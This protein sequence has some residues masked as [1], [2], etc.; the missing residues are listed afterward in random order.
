VIERFDVFVI[1]GGGTGS[2]VAFQLGR[3]SRL[4]IA[5]AERERLG[6]ECSHHGCVPTKVML[7]SGKIA[8]LG[9]DAGRFGVRIPAVEVDLRAV[10]RRAREVIE[11]QS[12]EGAAPF[13]RLGVRVFLQEARLA[14]HRR[15]ELADGTTV[16]ADR[17]VLATGTAPSIPPV[18]GLGD[19][20]HWTNREAIWSPE[21]PP[22][23]LAVIGAG[24]IGVEFAQIYAAFGTRVTM[25]EALPRILPA[26]DADAAAAVAPALEEAGIALR[27]DTSIASAIHSGSG[28]RLDLGGEALHADE[29]L[30]AAG[31]RPVVDGHDPAAAGVALDER[32]NPILTD[33]LRTTAEGVWAA[34]DA[35]GDLLFTHVGNYEAGLVVDDVLDR[36]RPRDYRV[37]PR[38]TFCDPEV[39]SVGLTEARAR[40]AGADVRTA[41]VRIEENERSH[42]DGRT[43]GIVKLVADAGT[44]ELLGGHIVAEEAGAMIH[45]VV[46]AMAGRVPLAAM[47]DA[48]H[49]YP[50]L[51]ES[52]REAFRRLAESGSS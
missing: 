30:V 11:A 4:R 45:E 36:P 38:V 14:G 28:W 26:E 51:S 16:E 19:G 8:R 18:P 5:L 46:A 47:A 42:I 24:A 48:I 49:A 12:G 39:A 40:D 34:G 52:V 13:E 31:R 43:F 15:V 20:P 17:V 44:G 32:G 27:P 23:S 41:L 9:R 22:G 1:G 35:T 2:E 37:V 25:I 10:Q 3:R 33:T 21:R 7:R 6:G 50:T 29:V